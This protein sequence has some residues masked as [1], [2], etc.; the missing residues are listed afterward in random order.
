M[1]RMLVGAGGDGHSIRK[2]DGG[3]LLL[4]ALSGETVPGVQVGRP[5]PSTC[6]VSVPPKT[7][8]VWKVKLRQLKKIPL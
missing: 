7:K 3:G 5:C 1:G 6:D 2:G 4:P 8:A